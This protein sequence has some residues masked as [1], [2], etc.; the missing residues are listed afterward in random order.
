MSRSAYLRQVPCNWWFLPKAPGAIALAALLAACTATDRGSIA[1]E[2][3]SAALANS[4]PAVVAH[5]SRNVLALSSGGADGAFG[6]GVLVGWT[7]TE[8]R[9][10]FDI[11]SGVSVGALQA[12]L[13]FLGPA[14]D[15]LLEEL[16][17]TT[18]TRDVFAGNGLGVFTNGG[19]KNT[20]PLRERLR[21][22]LTEDKL[23]AIAAAHRLGRR[24]YVATTDLTNGRS[25]RWDMGALA[26]SG[27]NDRQAA[28]VAIIAASA[29]PPGLVEPISLPDE[30]G[31]VSQHADG[32]LREAI[33][34]EPDML[35]R[36]GTLWVIANG[37][38][39]RRSAVRLANAGF[40][41]LTRLGVSQLVQGLLLQSVALAEFTA[42]ERITDFRLMSLPTNT[43]EVTNPFA[44]VPEEMRKLF[45]QGR[46]LGRDTRNWLRASPR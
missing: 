5:Q 38:F 7:A 9:P 17:T 15:S 8:T 2:T 32:G 12:P 10:V 43:P 42:R 29:S 20:A 44:F 23:D 30:A 21:L 40:F 35:K 31:S 27:R 4:Q 45:D 33:I 3:I 25:V 28:F 39:T 1:P 16:F 24:L 41:G 18:R 34:V 36:D 46:A 11:V 14:Y 19:L 26:A 6:A 22:V 13:A 37:H